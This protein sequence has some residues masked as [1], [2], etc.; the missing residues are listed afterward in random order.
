MERRVN[1][2][3]SN[4][5]DDLEKKSA[6]RIKAEQG[7]Y[8]GED[9]LLYCGKCHTKKQ[10]RVTIFGKERTPFCLCRCEVEKRDRE[11]A[12][13][14]RIEFQD[15]V[16]R[17]RQSGFPERDLESCV[18]AN[19]DKTNERISTVARN[20]VENFD[21]MH[22]NGK[23]LLFFG[24]TGTGKTFYAACI[25][26]ALID[27]GIPVL[28]TDFSRIRNILQESFDGRQKYLDSLNRFPLLILDDLLAESKTEYMQEIVYSVINAR[29]L[30]GLPL[31]VTSN[32]TGEELKH[33]KDMSNQ[34]VFSRLL[35][36][37]MPVEV[38]GNDRRR[39]RLKEDFA[40]YKD[41][42]GL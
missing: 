41:L 15:T 17:L 1:V 12:E 31:I 19:D 35:E 39:E 11:E 42:L 23:G 33:P 34:R 13:R 16:R 4:F 28:M 40:E 36:M 8:T 3:L 37:C 25:A 38:A 6:E 14:K 24:P 21:K 2:D 30:A 10:T 32:L 22:K 27:K 20:Y 9:G 18:F 7:D 26:N 5:V 29:Y